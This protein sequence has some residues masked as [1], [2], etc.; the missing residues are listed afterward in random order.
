MAKF[1][2][3]NKAVSDLKEIWNY[4]YD[5]WSEKQADTYY[6]MLLA[7]CQHIADNPSLGRKY[8]EIRE[9]L[10]GL[11]VNKHIIFYR[12]ISSQKIEITR[13]LHGRMDL[14]KRLS[15]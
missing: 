13:I 8:S 15:K 7:N 5:E 12:V 3:T 4:T 10:F 14:R 9:D 2:L 6:K 1:Y 11:K